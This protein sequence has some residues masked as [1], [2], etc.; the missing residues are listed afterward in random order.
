MKVIEGGVTAA[1]GYEAAAVEAAIKYKN[2]TDMAMVYST[3]PCKAAGTFTTNVVKAAP[4][5]WDKKVVEESPYAQ[6]VVVNSGIANACTGKP[7]MDC[8]Q[9]EA[10][11]AGKVLGIPAESVLVA[12]TGVI[13]MQMPVDRLCA[14]IEMLAAE[15]E[16]SLEA[17]LMAA[18]AIMTTD[19][20]HKQIAVT[21]EIDGE[22]Y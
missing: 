2:R 3:V 18:K 12:S 8:C 7:G 10:E 15:K 22:V 1:Q 19:T 6:A 13:G 16:A 20:V 5:L 9:A 21:F 4:V 17:G 14:G 11:C